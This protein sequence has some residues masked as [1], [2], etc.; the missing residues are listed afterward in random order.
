MRRGIQ[1]A[2]QQSAQPSCDLVPNHLYEEG[3]SEMH[4][5]SS[6]SSASTG[7]DPKSNE[8][9]TI[10]EVAKELRCSKAHVHNIINGKVKNTPRL[11]AIPLGRLKVIRRPTLE[12]W[13]RCCESGI[14]IGGML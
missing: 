1:H 7:N 9:L 12:L 5:P 11:P 6:P 4:S 10:Q 3:R 2:F 14:E 8:I 13:K